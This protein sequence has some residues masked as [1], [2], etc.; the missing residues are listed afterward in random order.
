MKFVLIH[1]TRGIEWS[2]HAAGCRAIPWAART[3]NAVHELEAPTAGQAVGG[4]IDADLQEQG[5][6]V[7]DVQV[8]RCAVQEALK[9]DAS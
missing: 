6:S 2:L 7:Y 5:W 8:H 9:A 3:A 4:W 1:N